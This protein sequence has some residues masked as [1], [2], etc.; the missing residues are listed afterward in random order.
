MSIMIFILEFVVAANFWH[1][2]PFQDLVEQLLDFDTPYKILGLV[3]LHSLLSTMQFVT[4]IQIS[5]EKD[6]FQCNTFG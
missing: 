5:E 1:V 2:F 6:I 4:Q 3:R